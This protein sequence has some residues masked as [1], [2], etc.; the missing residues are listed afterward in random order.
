M[1]VLSAVVFF[2]ASL[3]GDTADYLVSDDATDEEETRLRQILDLDKPLYVQYFQFL[4]DAVRGDFGIS[5]LRHRPVGDMLLKRIPATFS[6]AGAGMLVAIVIGIPLGIISAIRRGGIVDRFAKGFAI[7]GMSIPQFWLAIMLIMFFGAYL[8]V[9]PIYGRGGIDHYILPALVIALFPMAGFMRLT[10]S[11]MLE[12]LDSEYIKFAMIKGLS[13][14]MV[15][16]K[17][18]LKN[19]II[20]VLT[21]G[22][23]SIA[24]L[25]NGSVVI[26][27]VF[28]W[29]GIGR[30][31]LTSIQ[32]RDMLVMQATILASAFFYI[33]L[34]TVVDILYGYADPRIRYR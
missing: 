19:A 23:L 4:K 33:A 30:L 17:H 2:G 21:F 7:L 15:I 5:K 34:S 14:R 1:L 32:E 29:P 3:T 25:L 9:L 12:V 13:K 8:Q 20:P 26:E 22:G 10:R 27:I 24:A 11:S 6:L 16:Y 28:A 31:M 18:A